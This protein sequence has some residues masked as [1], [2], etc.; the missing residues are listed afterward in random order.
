MC[1]ILVEPLGRSSC[2]LIL[3]FIQLATAYFHG[4]TSSVRYKVTVLGE[5][6]VAA[7]LRYTFFSFSLPLLARYKFPVRLLMFR[8]IFNTTG[9]GP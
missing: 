7:R 6:L 4:F 8:I 2:F 9:S 1:Y 3:Q 5:S